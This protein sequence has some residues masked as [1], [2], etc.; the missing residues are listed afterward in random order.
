MPAARPRAASRLATAAN[1]LAKH[2]RSR[3][4]APRSPRVLFRGAPGLRPAL[5][6]ADRGR[7]VP[8]RAKG[9][10]RGALRP[11]S[12]GRDGAAQRGSAEGKP[13]SRGE[14]NAA[15]YPP[16]SAQG[17]AGE[18]RSEERSAGRPLAACSVSRRFQTRRACPPLPAH[19]APE[20]HWKWMLI[21]GAALP[22][23]PRAA[24]PAPQ[25]LN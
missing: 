5:T 14:M 13:R 1:D 2:R 15:L 23:C 22:Q 3:A 7:P 8:S 10:R 11:C 17:L 16:R 4:P 19:C 6:R 18:M 24:G 25:R 20:V 21:A 9:Q 12:C